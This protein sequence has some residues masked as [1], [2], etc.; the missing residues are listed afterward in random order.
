VNDYTPGVVL[1][2]QITAHETAHAQRE[3]IEMEYLWNTT[4]NEE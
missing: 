3:F 2:W 4:T 1:A